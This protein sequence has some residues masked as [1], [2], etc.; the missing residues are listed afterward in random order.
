MKRSLPNKKGFF[1]LLFVLCIGSRTAYAYDFYKNCSTG[2]RLYYNVIDATNHYVEITYPGTST[3]DPWGGAT[4][5]TG[6]ITLPSTVTN[7]NVTYTV[8]KI[9]DYAF[10]QCSELTGTLTIPNS[11]TTMGWQAFAACEGFDGTLSLPSSLTTI[12]FGA[13]EWCPNFTG[14][15]TIPNS[16]TSMG[17]F[18]F[19]NSGFTGSLTIGNSVPSIGK[20]AFSS[21]GFT[22]SLT[23]G[24]SVTSIG[25]SAFHTCH[26]FT[27]SLVIPNSV[28]TID[29]WAFYAC[30]GMTGTLTLG[31]SLT[32]IGD[33]AF[34]DDRFTGSLTIPNSVTTIGEL[35]FGYNLGFN[36]TLT[37]GTGVTSIGASAFKNCSSLAHV[38]YNAVNC[39]DV[40]SDD[41]PFENC[42]GTITIGNTV[43]RIPAFM[44]YEADG[45][46]GSLT[47]SNSVTTVGRNAFSNCDGFTGSLT[48]GDSVT[49]IEWAAFSGCSGFSGGLTLGNSVTSIGDY[50]FRNCS[51]FTGSLTIP[52]S[53]TTIGDYAFDQ[54]TG[55]TGSLTISNSVTTIG[56]WTFCDCYGFTGSLSLGN[57]LTTIS[58][59]AF[60]Y[61]YGFTGSLTIP[62]S[63]T[64]IADDAF[65]GCTGFTGTLTIGASV[66]SIG[67]EAFYSCSGLSS[68]MVYPETPPTLG[69]DAFK[70][71]P[72]SLPVYVPCGKLNA[73]QST[74][75][76][77]A[78]TNM[79]AYCD[80]LIYSI[81]PDGVSVTVT[82]HVD[83]TDATG[84][85]F[86]PE[87]KIINGVTYTV[88][89]I[90]ELAFNGC[91]GLTGS[92]TIPNTVTTIERGAFWSC[93]GFTGSLTIGSSV[94]SIG[95]HAFHGCNGLTGL[96]TIPNS[97][98]QIEMYAF[99]WC[100][101]LTGTL[102]IPDHITELP[103]GV[104]EYCKK[105]SGELILPS[106]LTTIGYAAFLGCNDFT[107]SLTIPNSVTTIG[108]K[109]FWQCFGLN[110]TL[111]IGT[112]V[113]SMGEK[114]FGSCSFTHINYNA[115]NCDGYDQYDV[116]PFI[117]LNATLTIG[118]TV[119]VI[120]YLMFSKCTGLTGTLSIPTSVTTIEYGAFYECSG[121]TGSL[122]IPNSVTSIGGN[123]FLSCNGFDGALTL[124]SYLTTIEDG[125]F[126]NCSGFTGSL[127]I[128]NSVTTIGSHAFYNCNSFTGS[129]N[130][131]NSVTTIG[132]WAFDNCMG[133]TGSLII[134]NSVIEIGQAA[135]Q[136]CTGFT[137]N[138]YIYGSVTS[139]G[140]AAF[141]YCRGLTGLT[142]PSTVTEIGAMAFNFCDH[143]TSITALPAT[144]PTLGENAFKNVSTSIPV[145]VPCS[146]LSAYEAA[147]GWSNFTNYQCVP[148]TVTLSVNPGG[149]GYVDF[150]DSNGT[151]GHYSNGAT[152]TVLATPSNNY[153]FM[154]WSKN[155]T[156]VSSN[157]S[158]SFNVYEDTELE[159][160]FLPLSDAGDIIGEGTGSS[161][162]LPSYSFFNYS[163]T[164]QI[165][166]A[167]ELEGISTITSISFFNE[168]PTKTRTLAI[169]L[170]H[171]NKEVFSSTTDWIS[172]NLT[173]LAGGGSVTMRSGMWTTI[174]LN[175]PFVYNGT[176]NLVLVVD[177]N[178]GSYTDLPHMACRTYAADGNQA[179]RIYSD[180]TNYN[181]ASPSTY[182]GTLMSVKNQIML[183]RVAYNIDVTS[184]NE[185]AGTVSG[186]GTYGQ[187]DLC[188]LKAT[189]NTGYTFL[190]WSNT[191]GTVVS[192]EAE[193]SFFVTENRTLVA[194]FLTGTDVCSLTFDLNDSDGD[195]WNGNYLLVDLGD[196]VSQRLTVTA[197]MG[198]E[199][200]YTLP[201]LNGNHVELGWIE[202]SYADECFFKVRYSNENIVFVSIDVDLDNNFEY[203]FDMDCDEM[204]ANW[205]FLGYDD[206]G[207][208]NYL[209]SYS[210]YS[211]S[212]TQQIYIADE[213]G[214]AG[215]ITSI[216]FYN[217]YYEEGDNT[218]TRTYDIYLKATDKNGFFTSTDWIS[219]TEDDKVFS[220]S[221]TMTTNEWTLITFDKPF[222]YDGIS[223]LA[224]IVDDNTGSYT[225]E[226][227]M[228]CRT[229]YYNGDNQA[230]YVYSDGTNYDPNS[231]SAYNGMLMNE[232]NQVYFG[233]TP[234]VDCWRPGLLTTTDISSNSATL[235]WIG[236]QDSYNLRYRIKPS[237]YE[238]FESDLDDWT[239]IRNGGGNSSTDW[240]LYDASNM[241]GGSNHSGDFVA[242]SCS[243]MYGAG[244]FSVDNWLITPQV[245][246]EGTLRF[247]VRC[248]VNSYPDHYDVYVS[249]GADI[250]INEF[251]LLSAPGDP[252]ETWTEVI[253]DLSS[254]AGQQGYIAIRHQD[255]D[256]ERL[257]IDDFGIY[258]GEWVELN[259]V[260]SPVTIQ[261][262][263]PTTNYEWQVQGN[264]ASC[265]D[266]G[267][268]QWSKKDTFTTVCEAF[269]VDADNPFFEDFEGSTFAPDCWETFSTGAYQWTSSTSQSHSSSHSAYSYYYGV[270]YLVLPDLE[271]PANAPAAQLDFWSYNSFVNDF[272]A[273]N[274]T[275]VLLDGE[276]E[277]VL[278][279]ASAVCAAWEKTTI[280]LT[281]YVGQT[282][283]I[284]FKYA[285]SNGNMWYVDDVEV[286]VTPAATVT[287]TVVLLAGWN[288]FS[289]YIE[290]EDPVEMLQAI[291][292]S[293]GENGIEIRNSQVNTEYDSEWGW[294]GDL[295]EEGILNEQM[296]KIRVNVPCTVTVEGTPANPSDHPIIIRK[297]WNWIGFPSGTQISLENAFAGFAQEGDKIRNSS[298]E[299]EYDTEW[300]WFGDFEMLE[301]GQGYMYYSASNTP[302]TLVFP[303]SAK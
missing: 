192:T 157:L 288:W 108:E 116:S 278:W 300:G 138:L 277:T 145:Y 114:A 91:S 85:L 35:A 171:T 217:E 21:C 37:I 129:L 155:G 67:E 44:F 147:E 270:N 168:G 231:P 9:G 144:P 252:T 296:Y 133:F 23:I 286:S 283:S 115:A 84:E 289:T 262:L 272:V 295:D 193:Y 255:F 42:T 41:K 2:Q 200:S 15:L 263:D 191:N 88:T 60:Y 241:S 77:N 125:T 51:G 303:A 275:V 187:G 68:M 240:Q 175:S 22:G 117:S 93:S 141:N 80:P 55:F 199:A 45:L 234:S 3:S 219:V 196:G 214:S 161:V 119:Q 274:N 164:E 254:Y 101:N 76:W 11:V 227:H 249:T 113:A 89:A 153:L 176:S 25:E 232:K 268:T 83:G 251:T 90:G 256:Q 226:P 230:I 188:Q 62:N 92:L 159:A 291:E 180:G 202:G 156:V 273:G 111:T 127:T 81:N 48:I 221:V 100:E 46:T 237:F 218:K 290:A 109:A 186:G 122:N 228:S 28:T 229:Y 165:Y 58:H 56:N 210:Y 216:A 59:G 244:A 172:A 212:L 149:G 298:V 281:P 201:V 102:T 143:L 184:A 74:S 260:T 294:W 282:V 49:T 47:I 152:C 163:L 136:D 154:H 194:N 224:L 97:V 301:P 135:F 220:G 96:L 239:I 118:N 123:A 73:Y 61:C 17:N 124:P 6:S 5:P 146:S 160:V 52:N 248:V 245:T 264:D 19:Y 271:L 126:R 78:F 185:T 284:A 169:Y 112:S 225:D 54:C 280:D 32:T 203:G 207:G 24:N 208:S 189:P 132:S 94:T 148:W 173:N 57:S 69:T 131:P 14:S 53:V 20:Y 31:N 233:L 87:A 75:G 204:P 99:T 71:V 86:I 128:P 82:G 183:N 177:D 287:Q 302:R 36:G 106:S 4:K 105:L 65:G 215:N 223:N 261:G 79:T 257:W 276:D 40:T 16:V 209:P 26:G 34:W 103:E 238:D 269:L 104:F 120:P 279:S 162:Y 182:S 8:T 299:I 197:D 137:G 211:Y 121:F 12:G 297:G 95:D 134:P 205:A 13:F 235:N 259:G 158:Y 98:T 70:A 110:G 178:T 247:W 236:E 292:A 190:S 243:W 170:M 107:G 18:A 266:D 72:S 285:G 142:L 38:N 265:N 267:V 140:Q 242:Q 246:L 139:I 258:P 29:E 151:N 63:V 33:R 167:D 7:N 64:T 222:V 27:G 30:D 1:A 174:T 250:D 253:V 198:F 213:I 39:A 50:A 206:N 195:G 293:L 66:S 166:T 10:Y 43:Q 181:P 130:I 179:L 150:T